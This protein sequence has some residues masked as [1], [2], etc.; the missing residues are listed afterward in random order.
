MGNEVILTPEGHAKL[1][2][3]LE[4]LK[5]PVR[6]RIADAIREAKA[7]GDLRENAAYHE[8]K[9]NQERLEGR[10]AD[11]ESALGRA[12]IVEKQESDGI[13]VVLGSFATIKSL[14]EDDEMTIEVV[15]AFEADPVNDKISVAS[16]L[17]QAILGKQLGE[18]F[19]VKTPAGKFSYEVT[20]I[21]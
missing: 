11:I 16:P 4:E 12:T 17:G 3:E 9:L 21:K 8:A 5:G 13:N 7:H 19:E 2:A 20:A 1:T 15:G 6:M 14:E 18:K 10:I